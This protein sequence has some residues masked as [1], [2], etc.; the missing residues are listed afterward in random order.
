MPPILIFQSVM[1]F[2]AST[3]AVIHALY[4]NLPDNGSEWFCLI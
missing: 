3:R 4:E 1:D 2:T